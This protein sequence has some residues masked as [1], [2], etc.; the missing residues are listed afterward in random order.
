MPNTTRKKSSTQTPIDTSVQ[1]QTVKRFLWL[2]SN[3]SYCLILSALLWGVAVCYYI[4]N[5]IGW[6]S[7]TALSPTDF[8]AFVITLIVPLFLLWFILAYIER[9]SSLDAN[10]QLFQMYINSLMYPDEDASQNAKAIAAVLQ[11]QAKDLQKENREILA[12]SALIKNDLEEKVSE[13]SDIL[14]LL[15]T[16][17]A[18]TLTDLNEGVKELSNRCTYITDKTANAT[19]QLK[20]CSADIAH[21]SDKFLGKLMPIVDEISALSSN[22]KGNITDNKAY[23]STMKNQLDTCADLSQQYV[24]NMLSKTEEN[25]KKIEQSFYKTAEEFDSLYKRLDISISSIEG[26]VAEQRRLIQTQTQVINHNSDLINNKLTKYGKTVSDEIDKL[27]KNSIDLEKMTKKQISTLK[28]VN[29]ETG[30]AIGG[31]GDIFDEKRLEI[32]RR[33]EYA[34]NSMQNVIVAINK[35]AEKL[36][37]FTNL[38]QA[39]NHDLQSIAE[40]IVDKIGDIS[41]KLALKTDTLKEK[42]V[43]VIDK[44]TQASDII[45][46]STDKINTSSN[47]VVNNSKEGVKLMEEQNFY[48]TNALSNVDAVKDKLDKLRKDITRASTEITQSLS[49]FEQQLDKVNVPQKVLSKIEPLEPEFDRDKLIGLAKSLN[50]ALR[51]LGVNAEKMYDKQDLFDL[52]EQYLNGKQS[53]FTDVLAKNLNHKLTLAI[54]KAFDDNAEFHNQVI[55]YLFLV[56]II[57]KEMFNPQGNSRDELVNLSVNMSL[58]KIYFVLVKALNSA[59]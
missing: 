22:I 55:R 4:Q 14:K 49:N 23:L 46:R 27:V 31:I 17:S 6:S 45:A 16:Y 40:T 29:R 44:F 42:A 38:T 43:E 30:A 51:N 52:W 10:A 11:E 24:R 41:N 59:D 3:F 26:R 19:T 53:A 34:V 54:R 32:E 1:Q 25:T 13:L 21:G 7:I 2:K 58:D 12:Q 56:D 57:I 8:S 36:M 35:E 47:L 48:L 18:K 28:A 20:Q 39:K 9:S 50:R 33:C 37:S 15:D 5:F